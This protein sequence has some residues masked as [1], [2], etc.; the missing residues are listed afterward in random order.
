MLWF[1]WSVWPPWPSARLGP[2]GWFRLLWPLSAFVSALCVFLAFPTVSWPFRRLVCRFTCRLH[3]P[4]PPKKIKRE[5]EKG[6]VIRDKD[7]YVVRYDGTVLPFSQPG[8]DGY[9]PA[10]G[11]G[12]SCQHQAAGC[13]RLPFWGRVEGA[14]AS[15][16]IPT[17]ARGGGGDSAPSWPG[18]LPP[19]P[20]DLRGSPCAGLIK[21][22]LSRGKGV[23]EG[24]VTVPQRNARYLP[25]VRPFP[26]LY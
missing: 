26:L 5:T 1:A 13:A 7:F 24:Q 6:L 8:G 22:Q 10:S 21:K 3:N 4:P 17:T 11:A 12:E 16:W 19:G 15:R 18:R 14:I 23:V 20:G 25:P 2:S 9:L